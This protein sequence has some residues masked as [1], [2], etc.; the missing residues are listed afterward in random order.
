MSRRYYCPY[1]SPL[2]QFHKTRSDGVMVCG[3]CGD[4]L[5]KEPLIKPVKIFALI[6]AIAFIAPFFILVFISLKNMNRE[7]PKMINPPM[8]MITAQIMR[9]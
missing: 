2:Y 8:A 3:Q 6:V 9:N 4:P 7:K 1:C 5:E